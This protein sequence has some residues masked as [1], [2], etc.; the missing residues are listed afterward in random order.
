MWVG[1]SDGSEGVWTTGPVIASN[2]QRTV[3][4]VT[5]GVKHTVRG[6]PRQL[7]GRKPNS[8]LRWEDAPR[9][10]SQAGRRQ[11][12]TQRLRAVTVRVL[13]S[14][15]PFSHMMQSTTCGGVFVSRNDLS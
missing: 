1:V 4:P 15:P 6:S 13:C 5:V 7:T 3:Q 2:P 10:L 14:D 8:F 9:V 11:C 12:M